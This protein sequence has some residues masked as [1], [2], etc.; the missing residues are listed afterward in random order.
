MRL[1]QSLLPG[2]HPPSS[3]IRGLWKEASPSAALSGSRFCLQSGEAMALV[4]R[5]EPRGILEYR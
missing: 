5:A 4:F 2:G 3:G 1:L